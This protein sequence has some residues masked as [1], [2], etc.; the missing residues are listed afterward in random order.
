MKEREYKKVNEPVSLESQERLV[1]IMTDSP[2]IAKLAGTEWEIRPLRPMVQ[3]M[4]AEEAVK[5]K[6]VEAK[7]FGEV[8][9]CFNGNMS[10]VVRILTLALLNDKDRIKRD[11]ESVYETLMWESNPSEWANFLLE[12]LSLLDVEFFFATTKVT[13]IF[14]EASLKRK[15]TMEERE[16]Y[17]QEQSL[18]K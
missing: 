8:L 4:I 14:R 6:K 17:P 13:Q 1:K 10:S 18:D 9:D 3:W 11:Y 7:N 16:R 2:T 12:V 5:I 15:M